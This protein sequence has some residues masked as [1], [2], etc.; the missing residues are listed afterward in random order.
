MWF[1]RPEYNYSKL[2]S[3]WS[4]KTEKLLTLQ[5]LCLNGRFPRKKHDLYNCINGPLGGRWSCQQVLYIYLGCTKKL[6][7]NVSIS[8]R[9]VDTPGGRTE[10]WFQTYNRTWESHKYHGVNELGSISDES[11]K[12]LLLLWKMKLISV[13]SYEISF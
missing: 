11:A 3:P 2:F 4:E 10:I 7:T 8:S 6:I 5:Y 13:W 1:V 9:L 12:M